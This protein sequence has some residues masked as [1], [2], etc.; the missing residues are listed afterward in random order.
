MTDEAPVFVK[1][2]KSKTITSRRATTSHND[3]EVLSTPISNFKNRN[4]TK[5]KPQSRL[6]FGNNDEVGMYILLLRVLVLIEGTGAGGRHISGQ[7]IQLR[8]QTHPQRPWYITYVSVFR[9]QDL[10]D[11]NTHSPALTSTL[12]DTSISSRSDGPRYDAAYLSELRASTAAAPRPEWPVTAMGIN[13][14]EL[15]FDASEMEGAVIENLDDMQTLVSNSHT[16][17]S[18][19]SE[20]SIKAAKEKRDRLRKAVTTEE[21]FIPLTVSKWDGPVGP[22]PESRLVREDDEMGEGDD[23]QC[24]FRTCHWRLICS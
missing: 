2:P 4:K 14:G 21:D 13:D 6:S 22:H 5:A 20:S 23:G 15:A 18:I 11:L 12:N 3:E 8:E 7:T 1:R 10:H 17:A 16:D 19:P 9:S 24:S